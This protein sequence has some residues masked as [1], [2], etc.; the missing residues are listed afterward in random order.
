MLLFSTILDI[1]DSMTQ[2]D[3]IRL[4]IEWNQTSTHEINRIPNIEWNGER[5]IRFGDENRWL[6]FEEYR[7]ENIIAIRFE[8]ADEDGAV[9]DTDYVMNFNEMKMSIRLDRS[10]LESAL[11]VDPAFS[12]PH[13]ITIL[14]EHGYLKPDGDLPVFNRPIFLEESNVSLLSDIISGERRYRLPVVYI[15]KT[16]DDKDPVDTKRMAGRLKGVAHVLVQ[17]ERESSGIIRSACG[18]KNEYN[19]AIGI[20][21]PKEH[22]RFFYRAIDGIDEILMEKVIRAV[23]LR[24]NIQMVDT[25][26]TWTGVNNALLRDLYSSQKERRLAAELAKVQAEDE[27][28]HLIASVD[29]DI[30]KLREQVERLTNQ[31]DALTI[32]THGLRAKIDRSEDIP[33]LLFGEEE[34]FFPGEIHDMVLSAVAEQLKNTPVGSRRYHVLSD[35]LSK[36]TFEGLAA[37]RAEALKK[38]LNGYKTMSGTTRQTLAALGFTITEEG[39]HYR[40]TYYGDARYKTILAKTGSDYREGMNA[41]RQIIRDMF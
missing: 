39:K 17:K 8:K 16:Y 37:E 29:D 13:F 20:Y 33:L 9:W 38:L 21:F 30:R 26:Y 23:I 4:A 41:S 11:V 28:E 40:L 27:A 3:F 32:E 34:E 36:N 25:L 14:I 5:N 35:I 24:S 10:Y 15:S 19:G 18:G 31:I 6:A 12:T 1:S 2:D 22:K 7:N